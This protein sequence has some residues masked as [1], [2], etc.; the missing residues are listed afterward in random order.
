MKKQKLIFYVLPAIMLFIFGGCSRDIDGFDGPNLS[1]RF[2]DFNQIENFSASRTEVDFAA[3]ETVVFSAEFNISIPWRI[4]IIGQNSGA[5]RIINGFSRVIDQSTANW[6][7]NT[8]DLP[9]FRD[10]PV[11]ARLTIPEIPDFLEELNITVLTA[12]IYPGMVIADFE[13]PPGANIQVG[14]FEFELSNLTGRRND[15]P[16]GQGNWYWRMHGTDNVVPNFFVGLIN[17]FPSIVGETYFPVPTTI[18]ENLFFNCFIHHDGSP[19]GIAVI[20]F[21]IDSN[22][23]GAFEDGQDQTFQLA[24]DFPLNWNGWRHIRH[25]MAELNMTANQLSRIVAVRVLLIS[26]LNAQSN[27][28]TPVTFGIDYLTFT[29]GGPLQL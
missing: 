2:G 12:R 15:I 26:N 3:G 27:P 14:N 6:N 21:A 1:D 9:F 23:S 17:I 10:E 28:P 13:N 11:I 29:Q 18:P 25:N 8:T 7:G 4:T 24:G 19:H 22:N 20:Q 16:A 5:R